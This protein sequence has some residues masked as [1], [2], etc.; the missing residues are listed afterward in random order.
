MTNPLRA[1]FT[2][3][4]LPVRYCLLGVLWALGGTLNAQ[5]YQ[6]KSAE[7]TLEI[8]AQGTFT[9]RPG[10]AGLPT[11]T[12]V[13]K[14]WWLVQLWLPDHRGFAG[15]T[16]NV[17][18][19]AQTP[20]FQAR[21]NGLRISYPEL[22]QGNQVYQVALTLDIAV[23]DDAFQ[24]SGSINNQEKSWVVRTVQLP[25]W[26]S[27]PTEA[28]S[29]TLYWPVGLGQRFTDLS[30]LGSRSFNYPSGSGT[31]P[32]FTLT[33]RRGGLYV[34]SH[35]PQRGA[36]RLSAT[37]NQDKKAFSFS[38]QQHPF[39]AGGQ[40][41]PLTPVV[42]RP[43]AGEWYQAARLYRSWFDQHLQPVPIPEWVRGNS[44][45]LL[46]ILKQ[47]NGDVMWDYNSLGQLADVADAWNL[48][49][50]GLFGWAH[51]GHDYLYPDYFPDPLMG[52]TSALK[53]GIQDAKNKGKRV[54]LYA[55]GQLIDT[56]TEYYRYNGNE[57][58]MV[59]EQRLP[60]TSAIRKFH[61]A[62]PVTFVLACNASVGWRK[63]MLELAEQANALGAD[64]ILYDQLGVQGPIQCFD[65]TH[66]H[67]TPATAYT[68]GRYELLKDIADH[69]RAKNPDFVI[70]SEGFFDGLR[71]S[72][73]YHHGWGEGYNFSNPFTAETEDTTDLTTLMKRRVT[74]PE[75]FRY[76]FPEVV[77][78]Q[79][80]ATPMQNR[81]NA[82]YAALYG[83]RHELESRY[84]ADVQYLLHDSLPGP[85]A[86]ADPAYYT[87]DVPM[88]QSTPP[89]VARSY[90]QLLLA[91][92][93]RF[94]R[95]VWE[96]TFI[97]TEGITV[98]TDAV[99]AKG[100]RHGDQVGVMLWNFTEK[101]QSVQVT[102]QGLKAQEAHEPEAGN[103]RPDQLMPPQSV[104]L[105]LFG[106]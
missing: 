104:R 18:A 13:N 24:I 49:V 95:M 71:E 92:Q 46:A 94:A 66:L 57:V 58:I 4:P 35:D 9:L 90:M 75:L 63:R 64:G 6:L 15:Q 82:N 11:L 32:W 37:Y 85:A 7:G 10:Q 83:L 47:Q 99:L 102:V 91:F 55:N 19:G 59:N 54:V 69:M 2:P 73:A 68:T 42:I 22:R 29:L 72:I 79:R 65:T 48:D 61:S 44:G 76:T 106:K 27:T 50:L 52:G 34:A 40:E 25:D 31:M 17:K 12:S 38:V 70:M 21:D 8:S 28:D 14:D 62:T 93:R 87:P 105:V 78:T 80:H 20:Q 53:K 74:Y 100:Y 5:P 41:V 26:E 98:S 43:Y 67:Q 77:A 30:T 3:S 51:G 97:D 23:V 101:P 39:C 56:G 60:Y 81:L 36:K 1:F 16:V 45:W 96:G 103:V 84:R 33:N 86:Y 88:M 89:T